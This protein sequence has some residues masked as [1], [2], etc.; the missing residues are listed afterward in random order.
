MHSGRQPF[1][2]AGEDVGTQVGGFFQR[3]D[4]RAVL[5]AR[6]VGHGKLEQRFRR[7]GT[8][9]G[10]RLGEFLVAGPGPDLANGLDVGLRLRLAD[11]EMPDLGAPVPVRVDLLTREEAARQFDVV[12]L[13][14]LVRFAL[15]PLAALLHPEHRQQVLVVECAHRLEHGLRLFVATPVEEVLAGREQARHLNAQRGARIIRQVG[16]VGG[17]R[18]GFGR[19]SGTGKGKPQ[20]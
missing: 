10:L 19:R 5:L 6:P 9:G 20:G 12:R 16:R 14:L 15:E 11:L 1:I 2:V 13:A 4:C 8:G 17:H 18:H 7:V 3:I